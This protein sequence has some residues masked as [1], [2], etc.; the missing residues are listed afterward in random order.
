MNRTAPSWFF[1][2][3]SASLH[4]Q[5]DLASLLPSD[6]G[7]GTAGSLG[8]KALLIA[9]ELVVAFFKPGLCPKAKVWAGM[10][11]EVVAEA[12]P[13]SA[14]IFLPHLLPQ[15]PPPWKRAFPRSLSL[16]RLPL[17]G[18]RGSISFF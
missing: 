9:E 11:E 3:C 7:W 15:Q 16:G 4:P 10:V 18:S 12:P 17:S 2:L 13:P 8:N 1:P 14:T 6:P 5:P